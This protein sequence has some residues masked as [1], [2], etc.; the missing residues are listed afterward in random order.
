MALAPPKEGSTLQDGGKQKK[1][2]KAF[3]EA[4]KLYDKPN[5]CRTLFLGNLA[6]EIDDNAIYEFFQD[7]GDIEVIV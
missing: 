2:E 6:F 4:P 3:P 5:G 1:E 7:C